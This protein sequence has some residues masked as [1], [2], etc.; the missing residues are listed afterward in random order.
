MMSQLRGLFV[1]QQLKPSSEALN[2]LWPVCVSSSLLACLPLASSLATR[3][4]LH[5]WQ[6]QAPGAYAPACPRSHPQATA[7]VCHTLLCHAVYALCVC[8]FGLLVYGQ[9]Q[10]V[11]MCGLGALRLP[12]TV[13]QTGQR[14][15]CCVLGEL[16]QDARTPPTR[17]AALAAPCRMW[18]NIY[19]RMSFSCAMAR[20]LFQQQRM[21]PWLLMP[22][23]M[24]AH[25]ALVDA[26]SFVHAACGAPLFSL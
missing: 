26:C 10:C 3:H 14:M 25:V 18:Q 20:R 23:V 24:C 4:H 21:R 1:L 7:T 5:A 22:A 6:R 13:R 17:V 19:H 8:V 11:L 15:L 12:F 9:L 16:R 2:L